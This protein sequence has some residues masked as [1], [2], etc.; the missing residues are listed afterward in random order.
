[1]HR[2]T[3]LGHTGPESTYWHLHAAPERMAL[4][5]QRLDQH[6][7]A[8]PR[9]RC[10]AAGGVLHRTAHRPT[11]RQPNTVASYRDKFRLLLRFTNDTLG[12]MP[13]KLDLAD[14]DATLI[15]SFLTST[16]PPGHFDPALGRHLTYSDL[17]TDLQPLRN[18][19]D[20]P[21]ST[22]LRRRRRMGTRL[23]RRS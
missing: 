18:R 1:M 21:P 2:S 16:T 20:D 9:P 14:L 3:Y 4:A 19:P 6:R 13:C 7:E 23:V 15:S 12:K 17:K 5:A 10:P 11:P 22:R 8:R